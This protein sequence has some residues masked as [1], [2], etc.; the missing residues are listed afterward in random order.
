MGR[1]A[2]GIAALVVLSAGALWWVSTLEPAETLEFSNPRIRLVPGGGPM[3]AYFEIANHGDARVRV[4]GARSDA[5]G[6]VMIHRSVVEDGQARMRH[7]DGGVAIVPGQR[8]AF[9]PGG[10]HLMLMRPQKALNVGD[11]VEIVLELDGIVP[12]E[13][14]LD[15]IV[16]PITSP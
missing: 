5:F 1:I 11:S 7:Q 9:A 15:F 13:W 8:V 6:R 10:L 2:A 3:A 12:T 16:V 4:T 14:P